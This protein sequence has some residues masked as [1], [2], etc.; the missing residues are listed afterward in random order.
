MNHHTYE[1]KDNI[2]ESSLNFINE[3]LNKKKNKKSNIHL[4]TN[5]NTKRGSLNMKLNNN[6]NNTMIIQN[7]MLTKH[8]NKKNKMLNNILDADFMDT[9]NMHMENIT[10]NNDDNTTN[11]I[12]FNNNNNNGEGNNNNGD[13]NNNNDDDN[14]NN[15][16]KNNSLNGDNEKNIHYLNFKG[17]HRNSRHIINYYHNKKDVLLNNVLDEDENDLLKMDKGSIIYNIFFV[18]RK[19]FF[20]FTCLYTPTRTKIISFGTCQLIHKGNR[21]TR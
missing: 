19:G 5:I 7:D 11:S 15:N 14:H 2:A 16:K 18:I 21:F 12:L 1:S 17:G 10:I 3:V 13:G 6:V 8:A 20:A 9:T 4:T